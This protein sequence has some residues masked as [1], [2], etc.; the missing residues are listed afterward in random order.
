MCTNFVLNIFADYG[1]IF[2]LFLFFQDTSGSYYYDPKDFFIFIGKQPR[3][4]T[5]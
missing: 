2:F 4:G 1:F 5:S 3:M